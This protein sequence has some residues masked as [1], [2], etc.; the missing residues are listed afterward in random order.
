MERPSAPRI[1]AAGGLLV[2]AVLFLGWTNQPPAATKTASTEP[3]RI[4]ET[5][6]PQPITPTPSAKRPAPPP[7][8]PM[9]A[10]PRRLIYPAAGVDLPLNALTPSPDQLAA[11]YLQPPIT[12]DAYWLTNYGEPGRGSTDTTYIIGHSWI[13]QDAPFNHLTSRGRV[14]DIFTVVTVTGAL[15]YRVESIHTYT[16]ATLKDSPAWDQLPGRVVLI[17]CYTED[18]EG[19]NIV[20][21]A[22]PLPAGD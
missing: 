17:S 4:V 11:Q 15:R 7:A 2:S 21:T 13:D 8:A 14:G 18:P 9:A 22:A 20:L 6:P 12:K 3:S 16:K 10:A 19:R 1:L 5:L